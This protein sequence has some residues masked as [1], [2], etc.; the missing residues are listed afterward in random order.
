MTGSSIKE[1][2]HD[3]ASDYGWDKKYHNIT[4]EAQIVVTVIRPVTITNFAGQ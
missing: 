3:K 4:G 1:V 2:G